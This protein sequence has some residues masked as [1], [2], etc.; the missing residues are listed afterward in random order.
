MN[1]AASQPQKIELLA[2]ARDR[3]AGIAAINCGADAVYIG[4]EAFS[5][6][7]EAGNSVSDIEALAAYAHRYWSRVYVA[8]NT[9]LRDDELPG[10]V[11]LINRL[12]Q[13]GIDGLIIQDAGLLECDLPPLALIASTQMDNSSVEQVRFL[14]QV[15]FQRV[16]LAR[17]LGLEEIRAIRRETSVEL[18]CFVHGALCVGRSGRCYLS[19]AAGGRSGNRGCCAQPC[20]LRYHLQ[21]KTGRAVGH[22][23][24]L[25]S[26][27]DL[28]RSRCLGDLLQAGITSLKI[29]GRLKNTGYVMNVVAYYRRELDR[30]L[31]GCAFARSSSGTSDPGFT[32]DPAKS[33]NRGFTDFFITPDSRIAS[34]DSP[35]SRGEMIGKVTACRND[36][37]ALDGAAGLSPGDGICFFDADGRLQGTRIRTAGK[38]RVFPERMTGIRAGTRIYRNLDRAFQKALRQA[39]PARTIAVACSFTE[40]PD[41]FILNGRDQDGVCAQACIESPKKPARQAERALSTC[42]GQLAKFGG[43]EFR[44]KNLEIQLARP[45]FIPVAALNSLRRDFIDS[46]RSERARLRPRIT[47]G[48]LKNSVPYYQ[49]CL[50][51]ETNVLNEKARAFYLRHGVKDIARAAETGPVRPGTIVMR[52]RY[53][54]RRELG[55]C[56]K[57]LER[58]GFEEPLFLTGPEGA[59]CRLEFD[60]TA[61]EMRLIWPGRQEHG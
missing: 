57:A 46:L 55:L 49:T 51:F 14:E 17:E 34:L 24:Y 11:T 21:D 48:A 50:S 47:G 8:L 9:I 31:D 53:C 23:R 37:F 12:Y 7:Q 3:A 2:P 20:R 29:E 19:Y 38:G 25:L 44:C 59:A 61:C 16:I 4:A 43:T 5:A 45:W 6:R 41:G 58:E 35:K 28:N 36:S 52:S 32:P 1:T 42:A 56:G 15:G 22:D 33:F 30:V 10:A 26:L 54:L 18:E 13:A 60:C 27:K 40:T 39:R